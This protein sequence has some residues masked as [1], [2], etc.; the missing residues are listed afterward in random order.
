M[1]SI[2]LLRADPVPGRAPSAFCPPQGVGA[3][4]IPT[5]QKRQRETKKITE[6]FLLVHRGTTFETL[7]LWTTTHANCLPGWKC[8]SK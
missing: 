1:V 4:T 7:V 5:T 8:R 6:V 3:V 2:Y